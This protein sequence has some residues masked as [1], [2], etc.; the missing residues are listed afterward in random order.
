MT[1]PPASSSKAAI[2]GK[3]EKPV[4]ASPGSGCADIGLD[5]AGV[6]P[7]VAGAGFDGERAAGR[8]GTES[9]ADAATDG[10]RGPATAVVARRGPSEL[11]APGEADGRAP[12]SRGGAAAGCGAGS[13]R[14]VT[15]PPRLKL[16]SSRGPM[17]S[18]A[19]GGGAAAELSWAAIG[20]AASSMPATMPERT[21][22]ALNLLTKSTI[23]IPR[24]GPLARF[25]RRFKAWPR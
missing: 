12:A 23:P 17:F 6:E 22:K 15:V 11:A 10:L 20:A 8:L 4:E 19:A 1:V 16:D 24:C 7:I 21:I 18:A 5:K 2:Q 13:A 14:R 9:V 25:A 3:G